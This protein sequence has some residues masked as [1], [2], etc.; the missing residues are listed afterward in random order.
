VRWIIRHQVALLIPIFALE[1]F[2]MHHQSLEYAFRRRPGCA[3]AELFLLVGH[4]ALYFTALV[5]ALGLN[6]AL[7]FAFV[8]D[9][10]T[11]L[12]M[13]TIFAPNHK[14]MPLAPTSRAAGGFL[15][16][17]VLTARDIYGNWF[18]SCD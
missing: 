15:R 3:R 10:V 13:A 8:H 9:V 18:P 16:D 2:S 11:G 12:Y 7:A 4:H 14:G 5:I 6:G 1:F 17:Q